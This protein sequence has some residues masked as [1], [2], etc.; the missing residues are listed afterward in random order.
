ME[1]MRKKGYL[2]V[3]LI[4]GVVI[5]LFLILLTLSLNYVQTK[6][7]EIDVFKA[8]TNNDLFLINLLKTSSK[9][10]SISDIIL[11]DY[12]EDDFSSTTKEIN[13]AFD[14]AFKDRACWTLVV[15]DKTI[16][17]NNNCKKMSDMDI[18]DIDAVARIPVIKD[19]K[20]EII[21]IRLKG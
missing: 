10:M 17:E 11:K 3:D 7:T 20:T 19:D 12:S 18:G 16:S 4:A 6:Q 2:E 5:A 13:K 9:D 8:R 14:A 1:K 21:S 15:N